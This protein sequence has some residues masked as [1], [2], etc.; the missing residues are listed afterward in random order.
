MKKSEW[1]DITNNCRTNSW[2]KKEHAYIYDVGQGNILW[3]LGDR[4]WCRCTTH[5]NGRNYR[6]SKGR[7][8]RRAD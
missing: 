1:Q 7:I 4:G 5:M 8:Y 6:T 3:F 2:G